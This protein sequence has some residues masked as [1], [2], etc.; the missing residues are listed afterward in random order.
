MKRSVLGVLW[1][2][3]QAKKDLGSCLRRLSPCA[4]DETGEWTESPNHK[5]RKEC[6]ETFLHSGGYTLAIPRVNSMTLLG[7]RL[8]IP[9]TEKTIA[10]W[11]NVKKEEVFTPKDYHSPWYTG[12]KH[13]TTSVFIHSFNRC[14]LRSCLVYHICWLCL[15]YTSDAADED[16]PV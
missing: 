4:A 10:K 16:S 8:L 12:R 11:V 9:K 14:L 3:S 7:F 1:C 15:L 2:V 5:C 13:K 6:H